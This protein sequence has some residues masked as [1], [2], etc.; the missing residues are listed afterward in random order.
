MRCVRRSVLAAPCAALAVLV[1]L[2]GF[3][4]AA[5][6]HADDWPMYRHDA[7]RSGITS[8]DVQ[9]P[10]TECWVFAPRRGPEQAWDPPK[11]EPTEGILELPR[12]H[13]D[14]AFHVAVAGDALYFGSSSE[15]KV[16]CLD[17]ATGNIRWT[18]RLG[19]PV[20]LAPTV[21]NG[22]VYVG[23]DD[24]YAYCLDAENGKTIWTFKAAPH[25]EKLLGSGKMISLWPL[26]TGV[27]VDDGVAYFSA[28]IFPMEGVYF[29]AVNAE[30]G[31]LIWKNDTCGE[32]HQSAV[33]PQGYLLASATDLFVPMGRTSPAAFDRVTGV[34]RYTSSFG[35]TVGGTSAILV[36]DR[37]FTGTEEIMAFDQKS[38]K[39]RF[40]WYGGRQLLVTPDTAYM[41]TEKELIA[42][43]RTTYPKLSL[44]RVSLAAQVE[45]IK[46]PLALARKRV[47]KH[48]AQIKG[49]EETIATLQKQIADLTE[50]GKERDA[51]AIQDQLAKVMKTLA[52]EQKSLDAAQSEVDK[53]TEQ[54]DAMKEQL[55]EADEVLA[56]C[57]QW[58][59]PCDCSQSL[60]LAGKVLYVGGENKVIAIA[61]EDGKDLWSAAVNGKAEGLAVASGK[62][63]VSTDSGAIHCFGAGGAKAV[64]KVTE[65][66]ESNPYPGDELGAICR[67]AAAEI[68]RRTGV[69]RGYAL[70]LGN[71]T[72]RLAYELARRTDLRICAVEPD[73]EKADAA[74][75]ALDAA[76]L[77]GSRVTVDV[78]PY[79]KIPYADYFA[80]VIVSEEALVSGKLEFGAAEAFRMLKPL[81]GAICIGQP[82]GTGGKLTQQSLKQW[83]AAAALEGGGISADKGTWLTFTRGPLPG[84]GKWTHQYAEPGNTACSDD[85]IVKAPLG[86]LWFG[87]PGPTRIFNR[88]R[89]AAAPLAIN[90]RLFIQGEGVIMAYDS[91]NGLELWEKEI[92]GLERLNISM[93]CGNLAADDKDIFVAVKDQCHRMN[94]ATGEIEQTYGLPKAEDDQ[95]CQWGLVVRLGEMLYGTRT[96][97]RAMCDCLFAVDIANGEIKWTYAGKQISQASLS[98]GD[99]KA[100]FADREVSDDDRR[101]ALEDR[102]EAAARLS[103]AERIKAER[104]MKSTDVRAIVALDAATGK[105][106]WRKAM[107]LTGIGQGAYWQAVATMHKNGVLM[108]FGIYSDGHFWKEF[109]AGEFESRRVVAIDGANG[110]TLWTKHIG[111]RVRP[112]IIGDTFHAEP[113]A[114]DLRTGEQ[115]MR[116][117]PIT[118]RKDPWQFARPG[119]HCGCPAA[120][121]NMLFF[122]SGTFGYYDLVNDYGTMHWGAQRTGCWINF[123][124]ANGVLNF[125]EG[126]AGCM[127]PFPNQCTYVFKHRERN[128]AWAQYSAVGE[129]IPVKH[130]AINL[131]APGDR[132]DKDG[133]LWLSFPRT[134][135]SLVYKFDM[136]LQGIPGTPGGAYFKKNSDTAQMEGTDSPWIF[137][138]GYLGLLQCAI[139]LLSNE[140]GEALYTVRLAFADLDNT[141][142]GER[143]FDIKL[144]GK[145]V[146][147]NFDIVK[148][149]GGG[150]RA[151]VKE[152]CEI[153]VADKL[154]IGFVAKAKKPDT[155]QMPVVQGIEVVREKM[156]GLGCALPSFQLN[157]NEPE[158]TGELRFVNNTE[159]DFDG[160]I[161]L[162]APEGFSALPREVPLRLL[163][164][165]RTS[166]EMT[167]KLAKEMPAG[168][169]E[170][171]VKLVR[172]DGSIESERAAQIEHMADRGRVVIQ[173]A[174]DAHVGKS[175]PDTNAGAQAL[176]NV[177]GGDK[178][179]EDEHHSIAYLKFPLNIPGKPVSAVL[180][181]YN[182]GNPSGDSGQVRLV[183]TPWSESEVTYTNRP[184][185]GDVLAK[186][187]KVSEYQ[188]VELPLKVDLEGMREL[189]VAI[190]PTG[191]DGIGYISKEGKR[192]AELI[193][194]YEP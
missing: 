112:L 178:K 114:Y 175:S 103:G 21:C 158:Q 35:K 132:R 160:I 186:I 82:E 14:D 95:P 146:A 129:P 80:N 152:F 34:M 185:L 125:P 39:A 24:G 23:S 179:M 150:N 169:Y 97:G 84:A 109:F 100:F 138:S 121:P 20:R 99:G 19:G 148:E 29:Y 118:G 67:A 47:S 189:S 135:G 124:P 63:F 37:V 50:K 180:R 191:C 134:A 111:Y 113:W 141:E 89:R 153:P 157:N 51:I 92:P 44:K 59:T 143:V 75:K 33:S 81:G 46:S 18:R 5:V 36:G 108:L 188:V 163:S 68:V 4:T 168:K 142:P 31:T 144:Q 65:P 94:Q 91:Y 2:L 105:V 13:F 145:V 41:A 172:R 40:A 161:R 190:E 77:F 25:E 139:P 166:L 104:E 71:G 11:P 79:D 57:S 98:F 42:L 8:E 116:I 159:E 156:L 187:G 184:D 49:H 28:G 9:P 85:Q 131:G 120:S 96:Q 107:D 164:G 182:G 170:V 22:R 52:A 162:D 60:I 183:T 26:R 122:R 115:K 32:T 128:R 192:P 88:H 54:H 83:L 177:D 90:G 12:V 149:A 154:K 43:N 155:R 147:K 64:G 30:D 127:C 70:V 136:E 117:H 48:K 140:D 193:V 73:S 62:L 27:L 72:G 78:Y 16:Y 110:E 55:K 181:L 106:V 66:T 61:P 53:L 69:K 86:L 133:T 101:Q 3:G 137:A 45:K 151:V 1:L 194:D 165:D 74:C 102:I 76:G 126:S 17:A 123:L 171:A 119:H 7:A 15:N 167:V 58:R 176:L 130:L 174:E 87:S 6:L 93:D 38:P 173:A 56:S 10:L